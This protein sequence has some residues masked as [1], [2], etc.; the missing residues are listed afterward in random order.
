VKSPSLLKFMGLSLISI[1]SF[2]RRDKGKGG[3]KVWE[4][5]PVGKGPGGKGLAEAKP[6][7]EAL[8]LQTSGFAS[9]LVEALGG[10]LVLT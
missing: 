6:G 3:A 10:C 1:P 4:A 9:S 8:I 5:S 2:I 7:V